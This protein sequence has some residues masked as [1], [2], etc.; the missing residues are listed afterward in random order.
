MKIKP[1]IKYLYSFLVIVI[2]LL[3]FRYLMNS[4][5]LLSLVNYISE[6]LPHDSTPNI[7]NSILSICLFIFLSVTIIGGF[8]WLIFLLHAM[9]T[10]YL[11]S[12]IFQKYSDKEE[13]TEDALQTDKPSK[14]LLKKPSSGLTFN[15]TFKV[16]TLLILSV[17][18][19][20]Y[21]L[22]ALLFFLQH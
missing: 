5:D 13:D 1:I 14:I 7:I 17:F 20:L 9:G 12:Y 19:L 22:Y 16:A 10:S 11:I 4:I 3:L 15:R 2:A 18:A 21:A 8:T 6:L